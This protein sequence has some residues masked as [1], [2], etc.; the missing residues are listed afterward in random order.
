MA[1]RCHGKGCGHSDKKKTNLSEREGL[2][3]L[4]E[5]V[6]LWFYYV[7]NM[8][9][10]KKGNEGIKNPLLSLFH[11]RTRNPQRRKKNGKIKQSESNRI[12]W[13]KEPVW[14]EKI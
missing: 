14:K 5:K 9:T 3:D 4:G 10:R 1:H 12:F 7:A 6:G 11:Q 2:R 8:D 13:G